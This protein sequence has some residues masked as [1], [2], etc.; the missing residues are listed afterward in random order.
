MNK[1]NIWFLLPIIAV[2]LAI[3]LLALNNGSGLDGAARGTA[4][5][6]W[7][8]PTIIWLGYMSFANLGGINFS[9]LTKA[10]V[11]AIWL[12]LSVP[13]S[14]MSLYGIMLLSE[15]GFKILF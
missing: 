1:S 8:L 9:K 3:A 6:F 11:I 4:I 12:V 13:L 2:F 15:T 7:F 5:V 14:L 10:I